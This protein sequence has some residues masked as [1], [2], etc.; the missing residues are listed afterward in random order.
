MADLPLKTVLDNLKSIAKIVRTD[1]QAVERQLKECGYVVPKNDCHPYGVMNFLAVAVNEATRLQ[2]DLKE[3]NPDTENYDTKLLE[4]L[5]GVE[6]LYDCFLVRVKQEQL[7]QK[8]KSPRDMAKYLKKNEKG[9]KAAKKIIENQ[10]QIE[11]NTPTGKPTDHTFYQFCDIERPEW[12]FKYRPRQ[13]HAKVTLFK[14]CRTKS[15]SNLQ[16]ISERKEN[17]CPKVYIKTA[18][19]WKTWEANNDSDLQDNNLDQLEWI[20]PSIKSFIVENADE[21]GDDSESLQQSLDKTTLYW[22]VLDDRDFITDEK[23]KLDE[24][25]QTQVYVGKAKNGIRGRWTTDGNNHCEMMKKCLD[26]VCA[27]T[28]TYDPLRL[29]GISLVDARLALAKVR[30][31]HTALFVMKT[32][33]YDAEK[34][35]LHFQ[36]SLAKARKYLNSDLLGKQLTYETSSAEFQEYLDVVSNLTKADMALRKSEPCLNEHEAEAHLV[37]AEANLK[38]GQEYF[39]AARKYLKDLQAPKAGELEKMVE[40]LQKELDDDTDDFCK[41]LKEIQNQLEIAEEKHKEGYRYP[42]SDLDIIPRGP[43]ERRWQPKDSRYG[44]N[45]G[46]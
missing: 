8:A 17:L 38:K 20:H 45:S 7:F 30:G 35:K 4:K 40:K 28:T 23:L 2:V 13:A 41:A 33:T 43:S 10:F 18:N 42:Q 21:Q 26:N 32:F 36:A 24:I 27:M 37:E 15:K 16:S 12:L 22:A 6:S 39:D 5:L 9:Q 11:W 25:R 46:K 34:A 44:M 3:V 1:H 29:E 31:E 14:E 19:G